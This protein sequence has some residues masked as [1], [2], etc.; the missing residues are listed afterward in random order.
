MLSK[1]SNLLCCLPI[2]SYHFR[3]K[4]H[5]GLL[6]QIW[7]FFACLCSYKED[8]LTIT[9]SSSIDLL[10]YLPQRFY[11][12][13]KSRQYV[14]FSYLLMKILNFF[15][16]F[17]WFLDKSQKVK[18]GKIGKSLDKF[19]NRFLHIFGLDSGWTFSRSS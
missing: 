19:I 12:F 18:G 11:L 15:F 1:R 3:L 9:R 6:N 14:M 17:F 2:S 8:T 5:E 4:L 16:F 10:S 7:K 13:W